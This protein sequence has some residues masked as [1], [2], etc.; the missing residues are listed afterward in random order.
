MKKLLALLLALIMVFSLVACDNGDNPGN[1]D[2]PGTSQ[3]GQ[4]NPGTQGGEENNG[5]D[6]V[7]TSDWK[8]VEVKEHQVEDFAALTADLPEPE[9]AYTINVIGSPKATG[10]MFDF[11][12]E[13]AAQVWVQTLIS[14]GFEQV[15]EKLGVLYYENATHSVKVSGYSITVKVKS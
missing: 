7:K 2:N 8:K 13:A 14:N 11:E 4:E 15:D 3:G 6:T 10:L 12:D 1:T 5:G 9:S